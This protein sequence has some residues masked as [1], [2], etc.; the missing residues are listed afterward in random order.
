[1][2]CPE[3]DADWSDEQT[4][5][6]HFHTLLAWEWDHN[7]LDM[8]HLLVLCYH[9]QH[10]SLYA[11]ETLAGAKQMLM[12]FVEGGVTPQQ[13][14]HLLRDKVDSGQRTTR[15]TGT[16]EHHGVYLHPVHWTMTIGDVT[17]AGVTQYYASVQVWA[18]SM[19]LSLRESGNLA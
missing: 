19:V 7:L 12:Q 14:R 3:C 11:P 10:P 1:M 2:N 9:L 4:C 13:M 18:E 15:I 6:E 17:R 16:P 8:H 5:T